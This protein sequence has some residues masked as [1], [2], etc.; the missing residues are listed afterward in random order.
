M[1]QLPELHTCLASSVRM[2]VRAR[3]LEKKAQ[4]QGRRSHKQSKEAEAQKQRGV[5]C[6]WLIPSSTDGAALKIRLTCVLT[7]SL[8]LEVHCWGPRQ[9]TLF[10]LL[11]SCSDTRHGWPWAT[12]PLPAQVW[13]QTTWGFASLRYTGE[14]LEPM[15]GEGT[16]W[17]HGRGPSPQQVWKASVLTG[18]ARQWGPAA[19]LPG[20]DS[21]EDVCGPANIAFREGAAGRNLLWA[22]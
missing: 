14:C 13:A 20:R 1:R 2:C 5:T 9:C 8:Q 19:A 12:L 16:P 22:E 7:V 15:A 6:L 21:P 11:D 3:E 4:R 17:P 10:A 18:T